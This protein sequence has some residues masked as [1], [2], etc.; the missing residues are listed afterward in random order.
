ML[1]KGKRIIVTGGATGIG[2]ATVLAC[3]REGAVI[4][5]MSRRPPTDEKVKKV[6][7]AAKKNGP[8]PIMHMQLDV[9]NQDEV[10]SVFEKAVARMG[11]LDVLVNCH[12]MEQQKPAEDLTAEDL[13]EQFAIHA[14][15]TAFTCAAAFR[16]MKNT[17]G[18]IINHASYCGVLGMQNMAAYSAAKGAVIGYSRSIAREWGQ[19]LIRVN[20]VCP[21]AVTE[22]FQ[23]VLDDFT[24][25]ERA[26]IDSWMAANIPLGGK[27]GKVEDCASLNVFLASDLSRFVHG[28]TIAVDGGLMMSR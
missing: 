9:R 2:E 15:G 17:G 8:G 12:G 27:M 22:L 24:A 23:R 28:Q 10:N 13:N 14:L 26:A 11:G 1:L 20:I 16:Y 3:A 4:A 21:A 7:E 19:Y 5:S 25:E 18:S 6:V